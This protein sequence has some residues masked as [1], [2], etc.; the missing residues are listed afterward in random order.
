MAWVGPCLMIS[1]IQ[2]I[3]AMRTVRI[4]VT[5]QCAVTKHHVT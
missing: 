2:L 1:G 3:M 4:T 5:K